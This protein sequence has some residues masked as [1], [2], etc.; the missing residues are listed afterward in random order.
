MKVLFTLLVAFALGIEYAID[1]AYVDYLKAH[2]SWEVADYEENIFRGWTI[3]EI[4]QLLIPEEMMNMEIPSEPYIIT[5]DSEPKESDWRKNGGSCIHGIRDQGNC[6]SCWAFAVADMVND[7][8]CMEVKDYDFLSPQELVSCDRSNNGCN[9]GIRDY[10]INYVIRN[11]LVPESCYRYLARDTS[12]PNKCDDGS[13]WADAHVCKCT[14]KVDC[15]GP[16]AMAKCLESG[17]VST[18]FYVYQ[19]FLYYKSGIYKWNRQGGSLGGHAVRCIG[20]ATEPESHWICANSWGVKWGMDG[21]F[22]IAVGE[23]GIDI[24]DPAYC[25]TFKS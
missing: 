1:H 24:R 8:C 3:N 5:D 21:Y 12:C 10:A 15:R 11:G 9:G 14:R 16:Q 22:L 7:R 19:D 18:G 20:Y 23:C 25:D 17:P 6:G 4:K 2:V 13:N